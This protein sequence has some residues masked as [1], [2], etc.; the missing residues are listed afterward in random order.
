VLY[1]QGRLDAAVAMYQKALTIEPSFP[2][3]YNNLGN[4]L[5]EAG[6]YDEAIACYS[7]CIQLQYSKAVQQVQLQ[8]L[9]QQQAAVAAAAAAAQ[10]Q[11]QPG[12]VSGGG[13]LAVRQ[14]QQQQQPDG[15]AAVAAMAAA[16]AA[17][18][19]AGQQPGGC[20]L[21]GLAVMAASRPPCALLPPGVAQRV[22][23]AYNNLGGILKMTGQALAAIACYEQVVLL[24]PDSPE[25]H[26]N[27]ASAYKDAARH[28][29]AIASYRRALALRP[30][31]PEAFANFVH[32]LQCVCDWGERPA[33]FAR[34]EQE[35]R[36]ACVCVCVCRRCV[37]GWVLCGRVR[38][39]VCGVCR[40][41]AALHAPRSGRTCAPSS[42]PP[43]TASR[44]THPHPPHTT[45][46][47]A[48]ARVHATRHHH[49][50]HHK[51]RRDLAAGRLPSVQPFHAMAYP[52]SAELA[53]AI[54]IRYAE[55]CAL[56]AARLALPRLPH[57][58]AAPLGPGQRL[59]VA[60][61]SSD[62]GNHPLSHLMGGVF[63]LHDRARLEVFCYALSPGDG[64]EWRR[65]IEGEAEHFLDVSSAWR[66]RRGACLCAR[67]CACVVSC[68]PRAAMR[69][70]RVRACVHVCMCNRWPR[71]HSCA[72][73]AAPH[74]PRTTAITRPPPSPHSGWSVADIA[75]K[76]SSD[77]IHVAVNLNGYT[78]GARNEIFA[79]LPAPVQASYMGFP[80]TTGVC[81]LWC[82]CVHCGVYALWCPSTPPSLHRRPHPT[83]SAAA[84][85]LT[86]HG[87]AE[88]I[89][90]LLRVL[91]LDPAAG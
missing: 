61:V 18:S 3:A 69:R 29:V 81:A 21:S 48:H 49:R 2:E 74:T 51:V 84:L 78:K 14:Q 39:G 13:V 9:Q 47:H 32:S 57:P 70:S 83:S 72:T 17:G 60:Y 64:S 86:N 45:A 40:W 71:R 90:H 67:A 76:I 73:H 50:H 82:V 54:S 30:D 7:A 59:R 58:P 16:A 38:C 42:Q 25:G 85:L 34:L 46:A 89:Q 4:A 56:A 91:S 44:H 10:Q 23:V 26:A 5:R 80:A 24:Q 36:A 33:L 41:R 35:V 75:R 37:C 43:P 53:L 55:H 1:E 79:L 6:R 77:G 65:R 27:L 15:A 87:V 20:L 68:V 52:F 63:G 66:L 8:Q 88:Q 19:S 11:Q 22:S 12:G 31:F 62:F 28:D